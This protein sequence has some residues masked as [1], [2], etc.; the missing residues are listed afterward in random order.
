[1]CK[2]DLADKQTCKQTEMIDLDRAVASRKAQP[3]LKNATISHKKNAAIDAPDGSGAHLSKLGS[4]PEHPEGQWHLGAAAAPVMPV[5]AR[6]VPR[7]FPYLYLP[8]CNS[9]GPRR[10]GH[11]HFGSG[12]PGLAPLAPIGLLAPLALSLRAHLLRPRPR[13]PLQGV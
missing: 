4:E 7:V 8:E 1:M 10:T 9:S 13:A 5:D 11:S 6:G 2:F 12:N 3:F